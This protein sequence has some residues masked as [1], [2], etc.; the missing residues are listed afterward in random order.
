MRVF[1]ATEIA[2]RRGRRNLWLKIDFLL[3][4]IVFKP[5]SKVSRRLRLRW[6]NY[7][8]LL[9]AMNFFVS[10]IVREEKCSAADNLANFG[11]SIPKDVWFDSY[12]IIT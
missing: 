3:V 10:H 1:L 4:S 12:F 6:L 2:P 9:K 8:T 5:S 11:L 7:I